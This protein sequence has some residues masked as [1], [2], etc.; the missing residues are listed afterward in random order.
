M[1]G[2]DYL[3]VFSKLLTRTMLQ[4]EC[5]CLGTGATPW[6]T[7]TRNTRDCF[8]SMRGERE[9][10]RKAY[11]GGNEAQSSQ[12]RQKCIANFKY[13]AHYLS[14]AEHV[15]DSFGEGIHSSQPS[16]MHYIWYTD[17]QYTHFNQCSKL[18]VAP[19]LLH[20]PPGTICM[21]PY[22]SIIIS[23]FIIMVTSFMRPP[24]S[25]SPLFSI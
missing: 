5:Y 9:L 20:G 15:Q 13:V 17:R 19:C 24:H 21:L 23:C 18:D 10:G 16:V 22:S 7:P 2:P 4:K 3:K 11:Y 14:L 12:S 6:L 25:T 8:I 1:A